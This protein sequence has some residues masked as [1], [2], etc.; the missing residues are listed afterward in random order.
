MCPRLTCQQVVEVAVVE[1]IIQQ[2]GESK[3]IGLCLKIKYI[4]NI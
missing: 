3:R 4:I 1:A 2:A